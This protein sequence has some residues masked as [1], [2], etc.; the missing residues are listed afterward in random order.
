MQ[1]TEIFLSIQGEGLQSGLPTLFIRFSGCNLRCTY[2]D[3]KYSYEG[4]NEMT[5]R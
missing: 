5:I 1:I 2:C 4:G 3:T